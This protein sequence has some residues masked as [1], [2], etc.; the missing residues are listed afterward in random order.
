MVHNTA[1]V[2]PSAVLAD[3]VSIGPYCFIGKGVRVGK[4]TKLIAFVTIEAG[5]SIGENCMIY[6]HVCIYNQ[7]IIHNN[8]H[9]YPHS[10]VGS[11]GFGYAT[12][13]MGMHHYIPQVGTA[14]LENDVHFGPQSYI[15]RAA[16]D[17][18]QIGEGSHIGP[19]SH[20]AHNSS[21]GKNTRAYNDLIVAGSTKIG[22]N[23]KTDGIA[24]VTGHI[25]LAND[26]HFK[27]L[28]AANNTE[29]K[30]GYYQGFPPLPVDEAA[31]KTE[32]IKFLPALRKQIL[33]LKGFIK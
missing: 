6:P 23:F 9:I 22:D 13:A 3:N 8:V 2:D 21:V 18:S 11:N 20:I 28:T 17:K 12:D 27:P 29:S 1:S 31:E 19:F 14:I 15:D 25:T 10:V 32:N 7:S 16:L 30:S 33:R 24:A 26:I 4:G 5:A